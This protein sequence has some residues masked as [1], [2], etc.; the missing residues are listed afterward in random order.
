MKVQ[1]YK[2]VWLCIAVFGRFMADLDSLEIFH[3]QSFFIFV[4]I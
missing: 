3:C 4:N 1:L 2:Y